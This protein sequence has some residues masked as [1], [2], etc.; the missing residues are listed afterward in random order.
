MRSMMKGLVVA[1]V[2]FAMFAM[3][4]A[5]ADYEDEMREMREMVLKLQDRVEA[6]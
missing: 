6:Q 2:G 3:P 5:A 1:S 4:A